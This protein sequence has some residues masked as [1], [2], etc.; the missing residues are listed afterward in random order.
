[1]QGLN[2]ELRR[3]GIASSQANRQMAKA[4]ERARH[5][6]PEAKEKPIAVARRNCLTTA[7]EKAFTRDAETIVTAFRNGLISEE[8]AAFLMAR[9]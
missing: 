6:T 1:M 8:K 4:E 7:E 9:L 3:L 2:G 5:A